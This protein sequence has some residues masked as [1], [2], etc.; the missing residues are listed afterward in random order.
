[1][2][3]HGRAHFTKAHEI[4]L[5]VPRIGVDQAQVA[6]LREQVGVEGG[7]V[8]RAKAFELAVGYVTDRESLGSP[9]QSAEVD[10]DEASTDHARADLVESTFTR[11]HFDREP[12]AAHPA[13]PPCRRKLW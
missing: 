5:G 12:S 1:M 6:D 4:R 8:N 3:I 9:L 13:A 10:E 11:E 2:S 7:G